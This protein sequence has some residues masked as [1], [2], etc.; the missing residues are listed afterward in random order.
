MVTSDDEG[1]IKYAH[2]EEEAEDQEDTGWKYIHERLGIHRK[3][4]CSRYAFLWSWL[5]LHTY[6]INPLSWVSVSIEMILD[7]ILRN[8]TLEEQHILYRKLGNIFEERITL[9]IPNL[10]HL[11]IHLTCIDFSLLSFCSFLGL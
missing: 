9:L 11:Q 4:H 5:F 10:F 3:N 8:L 6:I 1:S 2:D 7:Q